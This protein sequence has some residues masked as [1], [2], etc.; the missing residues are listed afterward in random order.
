MKSNYIPEKDLD[1]I[2]NALGAEL[3][4]PFEV[5]LATG[6][7]VGDVLKIRPS[8]FTTGNRLVFVAQKTGKRGAV[9][10]PEDLI[11]R[12]QRNSRLSRWCFP[13]PKDPRKHLTRQAVYARIKKGARMANI[14]SL[15]IS[16]HSMRKNF[17]VG[18]YHDTDIGAVKEALQHTN[19]ATAQIY[20]L[21]DWLT[22]ENA[23]K[24]L[25]RGDLQK[26]IEAVA[27]ALD[28]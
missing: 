23:K 18:L 24:P 26:I 7:R 13:S 1:A 28:K 22:G 27:R 4:L 9:K 10:L 6:L 8:D 2:K 20:A 3:W 5:S 11:W 14:S 21:A 12:L 15:G 25:R 19:S 17:A 16:P